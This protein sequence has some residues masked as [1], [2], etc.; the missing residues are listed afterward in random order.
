M[1]EQQ[2]VT[3]LLSMPACAKMNETMQELTGNTGEQN[4]DITR[5]RQERDWKDTN[6]VLRY[7]QE[8]SPFILDT[9]LQ[10]IC[11]GVNAH[12]MSMLTRKR[13]LEKPFLLTWKER[14]LQSTL[15]SGIIRLLH[16][17]PSPQSKL[18]VLWCR[19]TRN[20]FSN[21]LLLLQR[22]LIAWRM[23]SGMSSVVTH[24]PCLTHPYCFES[25]RSHSWPVL[26]GLFCHQTFLVS[27]GRSSMC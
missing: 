25:H 15:S 9:S 24:Q 10:N 3:W 12:S 2:R 7:L 4:K 22:P 20:F 16:W 6:T 26:S 5:A 1:T 8:R 14:L 21:G 11:T 17:T 18:M 13:M 27:L 23:S 19:L